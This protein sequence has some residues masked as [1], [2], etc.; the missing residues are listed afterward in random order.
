MRRCLCDVRGQVVRERLPVVGRL[1][2]A[3]STEGWEEEVN[4][5]TVETVAD[6]LSCARSTV[7]SLLSS[8]KLSGFRIGPNHG[9]VR[10]SEDDLLTYLESCRVAAKKG[11]VERKPRHPRLKHVHL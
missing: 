1:E 10:I 4:L 9:G 3:R 6:R 2:E 7:Y 8:G 11:D 5:L